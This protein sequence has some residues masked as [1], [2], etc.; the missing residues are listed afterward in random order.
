[1][2]CAQ[3]K[4]EVW[5]LFIAVLIGDTFVARMDSK[6]DRKTGT[7]TINNIHFE[8]V[9]L[10]KP[11][12]AKV[13]EAINAFSKFNRCETIVVKKSNNKVVL[14]ELRKTL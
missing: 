2:F 8:D 5:I 13:C 14:K 9:K 3:A 4:T 7:M 1:M 10:S 6:A 12:I 11:M